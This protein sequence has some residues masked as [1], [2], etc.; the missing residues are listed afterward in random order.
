[1]PFSCMQRCIFWERQSKPQN[2]FLP[3]H[4]SA[5]AAFPAKQS[6]SFLV[7]NQWQSE[8]GRQ[9]QRPCTRYHAIQADKAQEAARPKTYGASI[10]TGFGVSVY[11]AKSSRR[12]APPSMC[13]PA[14]SAIFVFPAKLNYVRL[15]VDCPTLSNSS[16]VHCVCG[17]PCHF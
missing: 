10:G 1:M 3:G 4:P 14:S 13:A 5:S 6:V 17:L 15:T 11:D 12:S 16:M 9:A 8:R 7:V 2:L